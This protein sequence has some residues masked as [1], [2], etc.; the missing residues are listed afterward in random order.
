MIANI[1]QNNL[2]KY[3]LDNEEI[4]VIDEIWDFVNMFS[5]Q[6]ILL[7][8]YRKRIINQIKNKYNPNEFLMYENAV[9]KMFWNL[10]HKIY[11]NHDIPNDFLNYDVQKYDNITNLNNMLI[12]HPI[13]ETNYYRS[14]INKLFTIDNQNKLL[15]TKPIEG[16][17]KIFSKNDFNLL[18]STIMNNRNIYEQYMNNDIG[19]ANVKK[20]INYPEFYYQF[21]YPF[22]NMNLCIKCNSDSNYKLKKIK[23]M[24]YDNDQDKYWFKLIKPNI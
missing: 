4:N 3:P 5:M 16:S 22:P 21:D 11:N 14:F 18:T 19:L 2:L 15:I 24:Y 17:S 12:D 23:K 6:D 20:N 10:R 1:Y 13:Y 8:D 9:E 7:N